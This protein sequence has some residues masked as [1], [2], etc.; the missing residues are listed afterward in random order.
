MSCTLQHP[1][2]FAHWK[3]SVD[4]LAQFDLGLRL[5]VDRVA[6]AILVA[7][8]VLDRHSL[9]E[10]GALWYRHRPALLTSSQPCDESTE[11]DAIAQTL[12]SVRRRLQA[13]VEALAT[14]HTAST[15][16]TPIWV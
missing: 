13:D 12:A 14:G 8:D 15:E 4:G 1:S 5:R 6:R 16:D 11:Q 3:H 9:E 10:L 2:G 7:V